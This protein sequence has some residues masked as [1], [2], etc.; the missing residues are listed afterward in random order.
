MKKKKII[1]EFKKQKISQ[2]QAIKG[3]ITKFPTDT[4]PEEQTKLDTC[5]GETCDPRDT[6]CVCDTRLCGD[7]DD[8]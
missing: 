5:N 1:L 2:L 8:I 7:L 3:G 4:L 6:V